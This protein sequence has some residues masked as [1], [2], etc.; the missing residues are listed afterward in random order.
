LRTAGYRA[1]LGRINNP[2]VDLGGV[3]RCLPASR[4][5]WR[6]EILVNAGSDAEAAV[7]KGL[8][9]L[10]AQM[11]TGRRYEP[12]PIYFYFAK[13][14]YFE[15]LYPIIFTVAALGWAHQ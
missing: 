2:D 9:W 14:W 12:T 3:R 6:L 10:V 4:P 7:N 11:E 15:T 5:P 1:A 8:A 13:L